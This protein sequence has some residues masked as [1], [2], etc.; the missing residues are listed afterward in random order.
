[1][2]W[3]AGEFADLIAAGYVALHLV[4]FSA[5]WVVGAR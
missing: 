4:L 3:E 2:T 5:G 1:V